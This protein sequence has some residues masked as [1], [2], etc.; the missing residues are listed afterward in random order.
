MVLGDLPI[1][2]DALGLVKEECAKVHKSISGRSSL[3]SLHMACD[4]T[5]EDQVNS[6]VDTAVNKL[7][8]LEVLTVV[9]P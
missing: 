7:G 8:G 2:Q 4:V 1:N 3:E 6:L 9:F 5:V